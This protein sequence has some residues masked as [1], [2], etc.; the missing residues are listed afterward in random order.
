MRKFLIASKDT[1]IYQSYPTHNAGLDEILEIGKVVD[2][3]LLIPSYVSSSARAILSFD[4]PTTASVPATASYFL[5]L[6]VA[7]AKDIH[8]NQEILV[9]LVSQSWTEGSGYFYQD[10]QNVNDGAT[11]SQV[12][13]TTSWSMDG[14]SV[15]PSPT[16]SVELSV[17]PLEDVRLDVTTLIQP[18]VSQSRQ[19]E[20]HGLLIQFPSTDEVN[21]D[22]EGIF[23]IFSTNTH[24]IYAPTLEIAWNNQSYITGSVLEPA[25]SLDVKIVP[26]NVQE[27]YVQGD[28]SR[29]YLTVRDEYPTRA[30]DATLRYANKYYLPSSSYYSIVDSRSNMEVIPFD[31]YSLVDCDESGMYIDLDTTPLYKGRFYT[32]KL[33]IVSGSFRKTLDTNTLFK[34]V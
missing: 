7:T 30:F 17:Y 15:L 24:T 32:L 31:S 9:Q 6:R 10:I 11:W 1:S 13:S 4:L 18:F 14:G 12:N 34:I 22:N 33:Q 25:P 19:Y 27:K 29:I 3:T 20:F 21:E 5:N 16:A 28:V 26:T 8:R 2:S 23:R